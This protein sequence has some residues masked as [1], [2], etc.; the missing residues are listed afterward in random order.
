[1][2]E[3]KNPLDYFGRF[4]VKGHGLIG[5]PESV[6]RSYHISL[7]DGNFV[8]IR[9]NPFNEFD[10]KAYESVDGQYGICFSEVVA[11][12]HWKKLLEEKL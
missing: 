6:G 8:R 11:S 9:R 4:E 1:M 3:E 2:V 10:F 12:V 5:P 7:K